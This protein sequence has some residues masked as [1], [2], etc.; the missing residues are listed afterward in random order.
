MDKNEHTPLLPTEEKLN[1]W[2][3][4][5]RNFR[6]SSL[7][8]LTIWC[9]K[10][11]SGWIISFPIFSVSLILYLASYTLSC[12]QKEPQKILS[13]KFS[14][15]IHIYVLLYKVTCL[16]TLVSLKWRNGWLY[17]SM[18]WVMVLQELFSNYFS[19]ENLKLFSNKGCM[20]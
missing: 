20:F 12:F 4:C 2:F 13:S 1:I 14:D 6:A 10:T 16:F 19:Q 3:L 17:F 11:I 5:F 9:N 18:V 8:L 7:H 15:H